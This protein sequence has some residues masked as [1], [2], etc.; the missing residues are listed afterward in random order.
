MTD[1]Q[2]LEIG[3]YRDKLDEDVKKLVD[4]YLSI[5]DWDIPENDEKRTVEIILRQ[6]RKSLD[7]VAREWKLA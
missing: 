2:E 7:D 4:K 6:I 3:R 1:I 5:A